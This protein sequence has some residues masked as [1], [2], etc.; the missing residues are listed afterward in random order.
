MYLRSNFLKTVCPHL[1][2][3]S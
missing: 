1:L 2:V 3:C